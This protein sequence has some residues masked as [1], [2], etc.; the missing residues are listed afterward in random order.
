[1]IEKLLSKKQEFINEIQNIENL[2]DE[3]LYFIHKHTKQQQLKPTTK[4]YN[5]NRIPNIGPA[6]LTELQ[7]KVILNILLQKRRKFN[8]QIFN[9]ISFINQ[10]DDI[11]SIITLE[12]DNTFENLSKF[13][14]KFIENLDKEFHNEEMN[15]EMNDEENIMS[16]DSD[17]INDNDEDIIINQVE[18]IIINDEEDIINI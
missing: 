4:S 1:M 8:K 12:I 3:N 5:R 14:K 9:L 11:I 2:L 16:D 17:E 13:D 6:N 18:D 10:I 7:N 15:E